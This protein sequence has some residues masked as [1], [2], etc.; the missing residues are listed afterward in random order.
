[1]KGGRAPAQAAVAAAVGVLSRG[2]AL[3][4]AAAAAERAAVE[5]EDAAVRHMPQ[6]LDEFGRDTNVEASA[7]LMT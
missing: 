1:M 7:R 4:A 2:S 5:A 3:S 6:Q